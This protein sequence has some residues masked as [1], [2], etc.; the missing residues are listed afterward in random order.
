M[1]VKMYLVLLLIFVAEVTTAQKTQ[2]PPSLTDVTT[3]EKT[4]SALSPK[5]AD[6]TTA[7]TNQSPPPPK[8]ADVTTAQT[9]Q[10]PLAPKVADATTAPKTQSQPSPKVE[11]VTSGHALSPSQSKDAHV[12][13]R[14]EPI[15][16]PS[17]T[18]ATKGKT[19]ATPVETSPTTSAKRVD[20]GK[21]KA[22]ASTAVTSTSKMT[23]AVLADA[24][25][26]HSSTRETATATAA[27]ERSAT[28]VALHSTRWAVTAGETHAPM[29][30]D[31]F[32]AT[33]EETRPSAMAGSSKKVEPP[34]HVIHRL[35]MPVESEV[36]QRTYI[37][38]CVCAPGLVLMIIVLVIV[39][40][41]RQRSVKRQ[42]KN[43]PKATGS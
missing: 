34:K 41:R 27:R 29:R 30:T 42:K 22:N 9:T 12:T 40:H 33:P 24:H 37:V 15:S 3:A 35:L 36:L 18:H 38:L 20:I 31:G 11:H 8:V 4:Q 25:E 7:Q 17:E 26:L 6:I 10:S 19:A 28:T 5:V 39:Y 43:S 1:K 2:S 23:A 16:T 14:P 32:R 21:I 13:K